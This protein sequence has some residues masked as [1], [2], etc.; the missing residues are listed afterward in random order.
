MRTLVWVGVFLNPEKHNAYLL[1]MKIDKNDVFIFQLLILAFVAANS[2]KKL[3]FLCLDDVHN[4]ESLV[5]INLR[6][7]LHNTVVLRKCFI[8]A[9]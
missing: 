6:R 7:C 5:I 1:R 2:H 8:V 9:L 4:V 3:L